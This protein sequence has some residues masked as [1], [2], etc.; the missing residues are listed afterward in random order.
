MTITRYGSVRGELSQPWG[1]LG[2]RL[3]TAD[4]D[5]TTMVVPF[6]CKTPVTATG[7]PKVFVGGV[8]ARS[9]STLRRTGIE[10]LWERVAFTNTIDGVLKRG[11]CPKLEAELL[12]SASAHDDPQLAFKPL[13]GCGACRDQAQRKDHEHAWAH[14]GGGGYNTRRSM[15]RFEYMSAGLETPA[16][17][18]DPNDIR[19]RIG[20]QLG[21]RIMSLQFFIELFIAAECLL[22]A[23]TSSAE[24][25]ASRA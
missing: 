18:G 13:W 17:C 5:G 20:R 15:R 2:C 8:R 12:G 16:A 14:D 24:H 11:I 10:K 4:T 21:G 6:D 3:M 7:A 19:Y 1:V 25:N 9:D 23:D 22:P